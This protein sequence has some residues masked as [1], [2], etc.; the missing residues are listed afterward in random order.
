MIAKF[1]QLLEHPVAK[2]RHHALTS[3]SQFISLNTASL[4]LHM[5]GFISALFKRAGDDDPD[6]RQGVCECLVLLLG[7]RPDKI[8]PV[9]ND[10]AGFM[11]YATQDKDENV[12]LEACE[13]WLTFAEEE[14]LKDHL[15][16]ILSKLAPVLLNLMVYTEEDLMWLQGDDQDDKENTHIA[17]RPEDIKPRFY[18]GNARSFEH[19]GGQEQADSASGDGLE[20]DDY[21]YDDDDLSTDW[22]L[23]KCAAAAIDVLAV[24]FGAELLHIILPHLKEKLWSQDWLLRESAILALGA[25]AEGNKSSHTVHSGVKQL[26]FVSVGCIDALEEHLPA[27]I[28]FLV[29]SMSDKKVCGLVWLGQQI[30]VL[31]SANAAS[32]PIHRVLD[33]WPLLKLVHTTKSRRITRTNVCPSNGSCTCHF[34]IL[35]R[36]CFHASARS[37]TSR[38][39]GQQQTCT[40]SGMQRVCYL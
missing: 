10:V 35:S 25:L 23:R 27:L 15:R 12:A 33:A 4:N 1:I 9:I 34:Y 19:E 16:P 20:D 5:D 8:I 30:S 24:R 7:S 32:C 36:A 28:P 38:C 14:D 22:N 37:V 31:T 29:Q 3:L 40:R 6:V 39:Y 11:L 17:D 13:F 21:D 2:M 26:M 18:G